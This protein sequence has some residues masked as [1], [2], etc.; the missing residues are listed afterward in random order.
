MLRS[1][2]AVISLVALALALHA[3]GRA[4]YVYHQNADGSIKVIYAS[5][6][7]CRHHLTAHP[8]DTLATANGIY[9]HDPAACN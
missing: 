5:E 7:S 1:L 9:V 2:I 4:N 3:G 6:G 8:N